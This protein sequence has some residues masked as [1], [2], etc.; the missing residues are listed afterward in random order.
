MIRCVAQAIKGFSGRIAEATIVD[1]IRFL[2]TVVY[3][4]LILYITVFSRTPGRERIFQGLFWEYQNGMWN[5]I[6]LNM[7]LFMP[8]GFITGSKKGVLLGF[9]LSVVIEITQ[10][11]GNF[12]YCEVDDVLN[13]TVG[14][15]AGYII[16]R[17]VCRK[18]K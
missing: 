3:T 7:F 13:N 17:F 11:I 2:I 15:V 8:L 4:I 18:K 10:Y 9:L 16:Y 1:K 6:F 5:N 12:G 14:T